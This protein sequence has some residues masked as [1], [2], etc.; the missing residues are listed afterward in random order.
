MVNSIRTPKRGVTA[1][2]RRIAEAV[3]NEEWQKVRV[4]M[5]GTSTAEKLVTLEKY[6]TSFVHGHDAMRHEF[7]ASQSKACL[8]GECDVCIR[9]DNY[10]KALCRGGQLFAGESLHTAIMSDWKLDIK[11]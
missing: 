6:F 2:S 11:K 9:V 10:I 3:D 8:N 1:N 4:S 5:K 7:F